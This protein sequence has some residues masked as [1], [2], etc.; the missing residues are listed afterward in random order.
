MGWLAGQVTGETAQTTSGNLNKVI[1]RSI[2]RDPQLV[3]KYLKLIN[4]SCK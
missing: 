1:P 4:M 2:A 3:N